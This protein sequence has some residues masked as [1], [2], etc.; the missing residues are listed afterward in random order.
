MVYSPPC[1][2]VQV[3]S[4]PVPQLVTVSTMQQRCIADL[5][6]RYPAAFAFSVAELTSYS[7]GAPLQP[8]LLL[9]TSA[10]PG[11]ATRTPPPTAA[12]NCNKLN[13]LRMAGII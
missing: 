8:L 10:K 11:G 2:S 6:E 5:C 3:Y 4:P 7:G 12:T 1:V 9:P 13:E